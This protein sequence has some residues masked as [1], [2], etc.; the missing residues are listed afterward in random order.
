MY[1]RL[2]IFVVLVMGS[3][4]VMA[5]NDGRLSVDL[6][7]LVAQQDFGRRAAGHNGVCAFV[8][9]RKGDGELLLA[10]YGCEKVTQIGNI[11]IANIPLGQLDALA[12]DDSVERVETQLGGKLLNDMT[13]VWVNSAP[14]R[15]GLELPHG[16]D[17]TGVLLGIVDHGFDVTHPAFYAVDGKTYRIKAFVDDLAAADET[18][19]IATPIGREYL[20]QEDILTNS[21]PGGTEGDHAT[22]CLGTAAGSGYGTP[23]RGI[24]YGADIFAVSSKNA[25]TETFI[26]SAD[27]VARMKRIFD[28]AE[29]HHQ[30]CVISY[31]IGFND[32]PGDSK[33][34]SEAVEKLVG[35][36]RILVTAAGNDNDHDTYVNKP[37]GKKTA[38]AILSSSK[39]QDKVFLQSEQPFKLKCLTAK[40]D[41]VAMQVVL[42]DSIVFDTKELPEDTVVFRGHHILL[43]KDGTFYTLTDRLEFVDM[44]DYPALA[45]AIEGE[46]AEVEMFLS[47]EASFSPLASLMNEARFAC[48]TRGHNISLPATLPSVITAGALNGRELFLNAKGETVVGD[49]GKTPVGTIASFSSVGPTRDG[50][51]KPDVVAPGVNIISAG[52]SFRNYNESEKLVTTTVFQNKNYPWRAMSGTSMA[53]P[54]VAGIVALWLQANPQLSPD[55]VKEILKTTSK[56][57]ESTMD[58]PNNTYGYGLIDA[59]A[60]IKEALKN[61]TGIE[62][63]EQQAPMS[64]EWYT[65]WG[66]RMNGKPAGKGVFIH[67]GKKVIYSW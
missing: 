10:Q 17:G 32:V 11:Y 47:Q 6:K 20:T 62:R 4:A 33:L 19:G 61:S 30:P 25:G 8:K 1:R 24:A 43:E 22:H 2:A 12:S 13:P 39:K 46:D 7:R 35:P 34:M 53:A 52:N 50:R 56:K 63:V 64:D 26:N 31:S 23:Y 66:T 9:F 45:L 60:G 57:P 36:G 5:G 55:D 51:I 40:I 16:Y 29:E 44:G 38:G 27:Q 28:Y 54:C 15:S 65:L 58:Y 37:Q 59:Y 14:V 3:L 41:A 18:K 49:G 42:T 21:H 48:A 67:Q